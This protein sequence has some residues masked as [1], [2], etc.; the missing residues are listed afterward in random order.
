MSRAVSPLLAAVILIAITVSAGL[1]AYGFISSFFG[2]WSSRVS[3]QATSVD[4]CR[5]SGRTLLSVTVKNTGTEPVWV[6]VGSSIVSDGLSSIDA[7]NPPHG[8]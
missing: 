2:V 7:M 5:A 4:I 8:P 3:L 1:V 6:A